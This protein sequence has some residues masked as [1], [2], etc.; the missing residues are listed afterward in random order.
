VVKWWKNTY[1]K[2]MTP[3]WIT[4]VQIEPSSTWR[5]LFASPLSL[6]KLAIHRVIGSNIYPDSPLSALSRW[7]PE[8][9]PAPGG[10]RAVPT[11]VSAPKQKESRAVAF[12]LGTTWPNSFHPS[13]IICSEQSSELNIAN[14]EILLDIT[15]VYTRN[16]A[17]YTVNQ[18]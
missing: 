10:S 6:K 3:H 8:Y 14:L 17:E 16:F 11:L 9:T 18:T 13:K 5:F 15:I 4:G 1:G 12:R 2:P 7:L